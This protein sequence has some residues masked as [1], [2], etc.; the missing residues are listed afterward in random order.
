MDIFFKNNHVKFHLDPIL[1]DSV[2][3]FFEEVFLQ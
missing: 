3:E 2:L 1:N